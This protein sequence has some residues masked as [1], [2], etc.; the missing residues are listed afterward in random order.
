VKGG[1][2]GGKGGKGYVGKGG[3]DSDEGEDDVKSLEEVV[4]EEKGKSPLPP[5]KAAPIPT[6]PFTPPPLS[7]R[8]DQAI[9]P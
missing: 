9:S 5:S 8:H 1:D 6:N 2:R 7:V 4:Y 3:D